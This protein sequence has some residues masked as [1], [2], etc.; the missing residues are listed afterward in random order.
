MD[1]PRKNHGESVWVITP[2]KVFLYCSGGYS[3]FFFFLCVP[4]ASGR[5]CN[6]VP[7]FRTLAGYAVKIAYKEVKEKARIPKTKH[8]FLSEQKVKKK[9]TKKNLKVSSL[10]E[11]T[12]S[13]HLT[14]TILPHFFGSVFFFD[15]YLIFPTKDVHAKKKQKLTKKCTIFLSFHI[16]SCVYDCF[17]FLSFLTAKVGKGGGGG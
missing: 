9:K 15:H 6:G 8:T 5:V 12:A 2:K 4:C 11:V 10:P 16:P 3:Y 13:T 17:F 1:N 7:L 14:K